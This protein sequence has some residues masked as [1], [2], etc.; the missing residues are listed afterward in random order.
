MTALVGS[1]VGKLGIEQASTLMTALF[2]AGWA[3]GGL[4]FGVY[5]DRLGRVKTMA[6]TI[7]VYSVFTGLSGFAS[8]IWDFGL[9]RFLAGIGVGGEFAAGA[10][11]IAEIIPGA[12]RP[13]ALGLMQATAMLGT[14]LGTLLSMFIE[15]TANI[16]GVE[17]WRILFAAGTVPALLLILLRLKVR[18][19]EAWL[20]ARAQ[21]T[22]N[23]LA[24]G[25]IGELFQRPWRVGSLIGILLG[26]TGQLGIWAIGTWSPELMRG[27]LSTAGQFAATE[28]SQIVGTGLI[29]KDLASLLGVA[30]FTWAAQKYGRRPAFAISFASSLIAVLICFGGMKNVSDI[31]WMMPLLGATVWSPLAGFSLYFPEIFPTRLRSSGIGLCYNVARYLTAA[32]VLGMAP[33]MSSLLDL[34][35]QEPLRYAALSLSSVYLLGLIALRWAPET[36]GRS[37][38]S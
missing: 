32:G 9:Y 2:I 16:G 33:L 22:H 28:K 31:W 37:L 17:G 7:L 8:N 35:V 18:E 10:A 23:K 11:L 24:M 5:G 20:T 15:A 6:L 29:L 21:S 14:L 27:V 12:L 26:F 38:P 34:G 19:S 13:Y 36:L 25:S 3:S 4:I 1:S 30:V